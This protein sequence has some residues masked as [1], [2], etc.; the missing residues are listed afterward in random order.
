VLKALTQTDMPALISVLLEAL[1]QGIFHHFQENPS[2][3]VWQEYRPH[4]LGNLPETAYTSRV[5]TLTAL[6]DELAFVDA[7]LCLTPLVDMSISDLL[8][9]YVANKLYDIEYANVRARRMLR[10]AENVLDD[11]LAYTCK[12]YIA[13]QQQRVKTYLDYL[14]RSLAHLIAINWNGYLEYARTSTKLIENTIKRHKLHPTAQRRLW[15]VVFDGMRWD[16]WARHIKPELLDLFEFVSAEKPYLCLLPSCSDIARTGLFA[17]KHPGL[18]RNDDNMFTKNQ[19]RLASHLFGISRQDQ[20]RKLQFCANME[21]DRKYEHMQNA[22]SYPYN[23]L[24]FNVS[25]DL[26]HSH[27]GDLIDLNEVIKALLKNILLTLKKLVGQDDTVVLTSDHGFVELGEDDSVVINENHEYV[28]YRYLNNIQRVD[29]DAITAYAVTY[30]AYEHTFTVAVGRSWFKRAGSHGSENRYAHGGLSLAEMTVPCAVLRRIT[31]KRAE[32]TL[33]IQPSVLD[34]I[35]GE[36]AVVRLLVMNTGNVPLNGFLTVQADTEQERF[37]QTMELYPGEK[38]EIPYGFTAHYRLLHNGKA[39]MTQSVNAR[40]S[41]TNLDDTLQTRKT[42]VA[43]QV[44]ARTDKVE[45][46]LGDLSK[47]DI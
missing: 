44:T 43:V 15:V 2:F 39:E 31:Q 29:Q 36:E 18:W 3:A 20:S 25:D 13:K 10:D 45:F 37:E 35:E 46:E 4:L 12:R 23:I 32:M 42:W 5:R 9:W 38:T 6:L 33:S 34:L 16:S 19:R 7:C 24:I 41:Y 1:L 14:D 11:D 40:L 17:G 28:Q 8:D 30:P 47:L 21:T 27:K 26:V 22:T